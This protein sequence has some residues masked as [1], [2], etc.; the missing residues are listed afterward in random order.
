MLRPC[1]ETAAGPGGELADIRERMLGIIYG[2]DDA[3]SLLSKSCEHYKLV[4][5]CSIEREGH[6]D[7]QGNFNILVLHQLVLGKGK[8]QQGGTRSQLLARS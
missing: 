1:P 4:G 2:Y 8:T 5:E 7:L 3:L 6:D